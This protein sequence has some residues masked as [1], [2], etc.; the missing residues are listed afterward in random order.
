MVSYN[1]DCRINPTNGP[2][3]ENAY[4]TLTYMDVVQTDRSGQDD[5]RLRADLMAR[6]RSRQANKTFNIACHVIFLR[7]QHFDLSM[8]YVS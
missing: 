7:L 8:H 1:S 2:R 6:K 4:F 5:L 3:I